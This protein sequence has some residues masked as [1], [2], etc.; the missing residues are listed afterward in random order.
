[1]QSMGE[2]QKRH[3]TVTIESPEL[4]IANSQVA[5][6]LLIARTD[7]R[8]AILKSSEGLPVLNS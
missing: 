2:N 5:I 6:E 8:V 1:M 3:K 7:T 4:V